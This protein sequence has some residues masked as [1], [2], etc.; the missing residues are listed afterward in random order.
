MLYSMSCIAVL[1]ATTGSTL[2]GLVTVVGGQKVGQMNHK[3]RS[4]PNPM[5]ADQGGIASKNLMRSS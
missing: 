3:M 4:N 1:R 5:N 2:T